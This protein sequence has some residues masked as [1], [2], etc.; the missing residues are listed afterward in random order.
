MCVL[1]HDVLGSREFL[2]TGVGVGVPER[3][4]SRSLQNL[5]G[6]GGWSWVGQAGAIPGFS[7]GI[8]VWVYVCGGL[9]LGVSV[10]YEGTQ[11]H[12]C[13]RWREIK[14][15]GGEGPGPGFPSSFSVRMPAQVSW[16]GAQAVGPPLWCSLLWG[17]VVSSCS[18]SRGA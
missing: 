4:Q 1:V 11:P 9:C 7:G 14:E 2:R 12:L 13:L 6:Q 8:R 15:G 17:L 18:G 16:P 5:P 3:K 10:D